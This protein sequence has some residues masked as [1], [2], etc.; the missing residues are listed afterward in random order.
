MTQYEQRLLRTR[1][2]VEMKPVDKI[3]VSING[4]AFVAH[5]QGLTLREAITDFDRA[6][7]HPSI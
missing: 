2:A 4:P 3:P 1:N 7:R 5:A 6:R